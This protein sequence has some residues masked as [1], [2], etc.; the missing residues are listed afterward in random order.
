MSLSPSA[1]FASDRRGSALVRRACMTCAEETLHNRTG[2]VHCGTVPKL[3]QAPAEVY[4]LRR[5]GRP[6]KLQPDVP[7]GL[8]RCSKCKAVKPKGEFASNVKA[9][10]HLQYACKV[11]TRADSAKRYAAKKAARA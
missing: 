7:A 3:V 1:P 2:C 8:K 6:P 4:A 9:H 11:C 10:D 5:M